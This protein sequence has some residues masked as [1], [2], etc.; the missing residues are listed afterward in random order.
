MSE[1]GP[2]AGPGG[3]S[4]EPV[5]ASCFFSGATHKIRL[6]TNHRWCVTCQRSKTVNV[7]SQNTLSACLSYKLH[8]TYVMHVI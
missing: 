7:K 1:G 8:A 2:G 4:F 3:A 5:V 6:L